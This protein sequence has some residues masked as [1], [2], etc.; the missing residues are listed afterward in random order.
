MAG[1]DPTSDDVV[2]ATIQSIAASP[3]YRDL[4]TATIERVVRRR[5]QPSVA[6]LA[7]RARRDLHHILATYHLDGL[8]A[9][10]ID[11]AVESVEAGD[12]DELVRRSCS[13]IL[14]RHATSRERFP[15]LHRGYYQRMFSVTGRPRSVVDLASALHP[16]ELR[17]MELDA[18]TTYVAYDNNRRFVDAADRY[19]RA[20]G[21]GWAVHGDILVEPADGARNEPADG[22][23]R[24]PADLAFLLMTYHCL[25]DQQSGA[26]WQ[27]IW[28]IPARWVAVSVPVA[29]FGNRSKPKFAALAGELE[30]RLAEAGH[31]YRVQEWQTERLYLIATG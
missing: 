8:P 21:A 9:S 30:T 4:S 12:S 13:E 10:V 28:A 7:K 1:Q 6:G 20:E 14:V 26:G 15:L 16:F 24:G 23:R 5:S 18:G 31:H 17:W 29:G 22:A 19:L 27:A 11:A 2:G 3:K 25:E